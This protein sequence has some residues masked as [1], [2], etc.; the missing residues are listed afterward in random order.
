MA[1]EDEHAD[2][3]ITFPGRDNSLFVFNAAGE[4]PRYTAHLNAKLSAGS[5]LGAKSSIDQ[6]NAFE[7]FSW[8]EVD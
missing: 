6:E 4:S 8:A 5:D 2:L 7:Q 3:G 1:V